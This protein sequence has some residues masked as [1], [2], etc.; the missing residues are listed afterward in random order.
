MKKNINIHGINLG[1]LFDIL[2][3]TDY[4]I[5]I[6]NEV[7]V[8]D[9]GP[10]RGNIKTRIQVIRPEN[11]ETIDVP[12]KAVVLV[13]AELPTKL[14]D[15]MK[16]GEEGIC[17]V[18]NKFATLGAIANK[19]GQIYIG[20]RLTIYEDER[21]WEK[22]QLPLLVNSVFSV[23][24][25]LGAITNIA[26][27]QP[28]EGKSEWIKNDF[29]QVKTD[30]SHA[31]FCSAD[32]SGF[33]AEFALSDSDVSAELGH[34]TALLVISANQPH[35]YL[36]GGIF[37]KLELPYNFSDKNYLYSVCMK[38]NNLEMEPCDLPPHFGAWTI[39]VHGG[40]AY[41]CFFANP[42]YE[43]I[44]RI[45]SNV[46]FWM[47]ARAHWVNTKLASLGAGKIVAN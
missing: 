25:I 33:T 3:Q 30:L 7:L 18:S 21:A 22:L 43:M 31:C 20:S 26:N 8:A 11:R 46:A 24:S 19:Q 29:E 5:S 23:E 47:G 45:A 35:P 15:I 1:A 6:D 42:I 41:I 17:V 27:N 38:L 9:A 34:K 40:L 2:E 10:T 14:A 12:I 37:C 28:S 39:G 13:T 16:L 32:D 44:P 36:G 4:K